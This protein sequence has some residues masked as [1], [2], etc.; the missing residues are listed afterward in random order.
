MRDN[1]ILASAIKTFGER[2]QEEKAIEE[3]AELICAIAHKHCGADMRLRN[4]TEM[5]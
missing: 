5:L 2:A 3:L 4:D 1:E